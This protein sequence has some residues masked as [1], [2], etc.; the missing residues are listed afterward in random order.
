MADKKIIGQPTSIV[1]GQVTLA[2]LQSVKK[3]L[4]EAQL[5]SGD[6]VSKV[7][8]VVETVRSR[9]EEESFRNGREIL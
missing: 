3:F 2:D 8:D 5:V 1:H 7:N 4:L 9:S 6:I